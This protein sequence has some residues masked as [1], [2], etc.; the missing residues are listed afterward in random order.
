[1]LAQHHL[2]PEAL[3]RHRYRAQQTPSPPWSPGN[4]LGLP[5]EPPPM[6]SAWS[7]P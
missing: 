1:V 3:Q 7:R 4:Q 6:R 2:S 5:F